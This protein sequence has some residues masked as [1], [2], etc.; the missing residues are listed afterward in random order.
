V[1]LKTPLPPHHTRKANAQSRNNDVHQSPILKN[2]SKALYLCFQSLLLDLDRS[3]KKDSDVDPHEEYLAA[4][5]CIARCVDMFCNIDKTIDIG[6]LLKQHELADASED[7]DD[8][9][10]R[11]KKLSKLYIR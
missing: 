4:A 1:N 8:I 11:D 7:K 2:Q 3:K 5:R 9:T 10:R 6:M